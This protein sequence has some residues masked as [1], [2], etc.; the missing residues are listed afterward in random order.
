MN[1][2]DDKFLREHVR[3]SLLEDIGGGD[4]T[5]RLTVDDHLT[6][7]AAA[8]SREEGVFAGS[9][10][11]ETVYSVLSAIDESLNDHPVD[12][13]WSVS[14]GDKITAGQKL[15]EANGNV[16]LLLTGERVVLNYLQQLSGVATKTFRMVKIAR[17]YGVKIYDTRKT[18][19]HHRILQKYAVSCGQGDNHRL[20]LA[21]AVMIK[22]NH[23]LAAG[24]L[25]EALRRVEG[26]LPLIV[27]IHSPEE[28]KIVSDFDIDVVMLDNMFPETVKK[29][30]SRVPEKM[31]VEISGGITLDNLREYCETGV[32]RISVGSLTHSFQSLDI[33][34][35]L[36][37]N[38]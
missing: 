14:D 23:K 28:L 9:S 2:M 36:I 1:T 10:I 7:R 30:V 8:V 6:G 34:L 3:A 12:I 38:E 15:F 31:S 5:S 21:D 33:S 29:I 35:G 24:G 27:E 32:D 20:T 17:E 37:K 4:I 22:D 13:K 26:D 18:V 11:V 25:R 16:G 19:P